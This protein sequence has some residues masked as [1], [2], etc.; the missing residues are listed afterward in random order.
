MIQQNN[1]QKFKGNVEIIQD[2]CHVCVTMPFSSHISVVPDGN[3]I[4]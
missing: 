1:A 4:K 2:G 3:M